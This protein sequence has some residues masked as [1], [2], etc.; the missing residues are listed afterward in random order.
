MSSLWKN[1]TS[2]QELWELKRKKKKEEDDK[3]NDSNAVVDYCYS[4]DGDILTVSEAQIKTEGS[5]YTGSHSEE[6]KEW[7]LDS[8]CTYHM[9][10]IKEWFHDYTSVSGGNVVM[11]NDQ[12]CKVIGIGSITLKSYD[13]TL[14]TLNKVRHIP[15]LKRNLIFLGTLDEEGYECKVINGVMKI[16]KGSLLSLKGNKRNGLYYLDGETEFHGVAA[17]VKKSNAESK[18]W[19]A[20]L[21]H[22]GEQGLIELS[23]QGMLKNYTHNNLPFCEICVQGKQHRIKFTSSSYRAKGVLEYVHADL[24]GPSKVNTS[25]GSRFFLSI[26]DDFSRKT[27]V[28]L[29]KYKSETLAAFKNWKIL[30][31][32]QTNTKLKVLRTDNGLEFVNDEFN[33]LCLEYGIERHRTV[34]KTPQQNGIAERMNRTLLNKVRCLLLESGLAK[35]FWGEAL[36]TACY[37]INRSPN[38]KI[39]SKTPEELWKGKQPSL[40]HLKIFGCAAYAHKVEDK[41]GKRSEKC[42]FLGYPNGIK[43]YRLLSIETNK[44]IISRDVIFN[45]YDFP[46]KRNEEDILS[47][48]AGNK[49]KS[50]TQFEIEM[51]L[52]H[53]EEQTEVEPEISEDSECQDEDLTNYQLAR[54]RVRREIRA[55]I[56]YSEADTIARIGE[57]DI[58][59]F[60]LSM[61]TEKNSKA[62]SNYEEAVSSKHAEKWT[63]AMEEE[64]MSLK[65]N[66]TWTLVPKPHGQK[67]IGCKWIYKI[68]EGLTEQDPKVY[69]ARLVAKGFTQVEGIDYT[70]IFSP[71]IKMKTIRLMMAAAVQFDWEIEQMDVKTAFLNG[72]LEETIY[73]SQPDGF[74]VESNKEELVCLLQ[75]SLY[76]LKQSPRQWYKKFDSVITKIGYL[77]SKYDTCLYY[78]NLNTQAATFLLIYVDDML[79]CNGTN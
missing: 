15:D 19:H 35:K 9:C 42:I 56:K 20:R 18:T 46:F 77:R 29:L 69:K 62:P 57:A 26:V 13:G 5:V 49:E 25:G 78:T 31:E 64:I 53:H 72:K 16:Y 34:I 38:R 47:D 43:G 66:K 32:T 37:L 68:K 3:S 55:P 11:G 12:K 74:K 45:E 10:P 67:V 39:D 61:T 63:K 6:W 1:R 75:R 54:D 23:K 17:T 76:G 52:I 59:A 79:I 14:K 65:K 36:Y 4:S 27:W 58:I 24:W 8:G 28:Y 50:D 30:V 70:E 33:K 44:V 7:I 2:N 71:V 22:I 41:L 48:I 73:M 51:T 21:G 40:T 60:A